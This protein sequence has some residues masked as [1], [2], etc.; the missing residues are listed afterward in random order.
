MILVDKKQNTLNIDYSISITPSPFGYP[1]LPP[2]KPKQV[3]KIFEGIW[4]AIAAS[5][6]L[7]YPIFYSITN[8]QNFKPL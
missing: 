5:K 4:L 8:K 3:A 2:S 7:S 1:G 6:L